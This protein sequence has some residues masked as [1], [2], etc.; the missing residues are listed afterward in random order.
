MKGKKVMNNQSEGKKYPEQITVGSSRLKKSKDEL[1]VALRPELR[2]VEVD[3]FFDE[4]RALVEW[5]FEPTDKK[6]LALKKFNT[7]SVSAKWV[8]R[9]EGRTESIDQLIGKIEVDERVNIVGPIYFREDLK[10]PNGFTFNDQ[11]IIRFDEKK[12]K[13]QELQVVFQELGVKKVEGRLGDLGKGWMLLRVIDKKNQNTYEIAQKLAKSKLVKS[14][15]VDWIQ[16][17]NGLQFVPNDQYFFK[18]WA[19]LN[20]GTQQMPDG[21][22]G[23]LDCDINAEKAWDISNG[24]PLVVIAV[25]DTGCDLGH[26]DLVPNYVQTDRW[27]NAYNGTNSPG[28]KD[29]HGTCCAGIASASTNNGQGVAGV[30]CRCRIMP[31]TTHPMELFGG[32]DLSFIINAL[33]WAINH[34]VDVI[35]ISWVWDLAEGNFDAKLKDCFDAGIVIVACSGNYD[36]GVIR[37][38]AK[39]EHV[40]AVGATNEN[41]KRCTKIDW[42]DD[43]T[44]PGSNYGDELSVVAPGVHLWTT[45]I[46]GVLPSAPTSI[47]DLFVGFNDLKGGGDAA[48]D[49]FEDF[50]GTSGATAH[51]AGLAGLILAYNPT[52]TPTQVREIIEKTADDQVGYPTEDTP[53]WDKYMGHGRINAH[54][55]LVHVQTNYPFEPADVYIRS[56]LNDNGTEP[57]NDSPLC[58]SPDIIVKQNPV[59]TPQTAFAD[60]TVDPGSDNVAIGNDNYIYVRVHNK[61]TSKESD[62]HVRLYFAPLTTTCTPDQWN[63]LGQI[64]FYD[65]PAGGHA[66]SDALIWENVPDPGPVGHFCIIASIEGARDPHPDPSGITNAIDYVQFIR[67]HNNICYRNVTFAEVLSNTSLS[68]NFFVAGFVGDPI[69]SA[70]RIE[71][72]GPAR[73]AKIGLKFPKIILK[74]RVNLENMVERPEAA[75]K[76]FRFFALDEGK[77]VSLIKGLVIPGGRGI[78]EIYVRIPAEARP[79]D[80]YKMSIQQVAKHKI[81]GDLQIIAKVV[82]PKKSRYIAIRG[83]H[84]VHKANCKALTENNRQLWVPFESLDAA[85]AAGYDMALDCLNQQ[86]TVKDVS[87]QLARRVLAFVNKV[88]LA[89]DLNQAVGNTL[90]I[91]YFERRYGKEKAKKRGYGLGKGVAKEILKARSKV[92]RFTK[93]EELKAVK[94]VDIDILIDIV[95]TF[96]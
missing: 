24:S 81:V 36:E 13:K 83:S 7:F 43:P 84:L 88:E 26:P 94:G 92:G 60:M 70:L 64:D 3:N 46:R 11:I 69:R 85:R 34:H 31:I 51:V 80:V 67:K 35:S 86:F 63:Y 45:D 29:G 74:G 16:L 56:S 27:Y 48:G 91:N 17:H 33:N 73:R 52:L 61:E 1:Y 12:I 6:A 10:Y 20:T 4:K 71:R 47:E 38:P 42:P 68:L 21:A 96:K 9:A 23:T 53:G 39:N 40:I 41:D 32:S 19:H 54:A 66:V 58:Y 49:Y 89:E 2:K 30:G 77:K 79:D 22:Y 8:T 18:Q 25:L 62:I 37:Y 15:V 57:Y 87:Y 14:A 44:K 90:D 75:S 82:D 5:E 76:G 78:A 65:I 28:D 55:A 59:P 95:N 93:L 50:G 72:E